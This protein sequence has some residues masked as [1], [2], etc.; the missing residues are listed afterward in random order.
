[1][2][3]VGE[4]RRR[5]STQM[6]WSKRGEGGIQSLGDRPSK[7]DPLETMDVIESEAA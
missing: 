7:E 1:M 2:G 3:G 4:R 6:G 5:K